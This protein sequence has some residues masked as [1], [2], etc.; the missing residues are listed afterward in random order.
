MYKD[1]STREVCKRKDL[2]L[3]IWDSEDD[4]G[5]HTQYVVC[6]D[7]NPNE[8]IGSQWWGGHYF[9]DAYDAFEFLQNETETVGRYRAIEIAT[10][11]LDDEERED[12]IATEL[13][14]E[15]REYFGLESE[16]E[17]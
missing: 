4:Y 12:W 13:T 14:D 11:A 16:E 9:K 17:D 7:Y 1:I 2:S 15:E 6:H 10:W 5:R 8:K 3:V